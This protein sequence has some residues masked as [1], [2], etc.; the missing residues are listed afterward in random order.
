MSDLIATTGQIKEGQAGYR[1]G[2]TG[3]AF[4][5][6]YQG[7]S[8]AIASG[9]WIDGSIA[10]LGAALNVGSTLIDPF[11]TL[12]AMG[13]EWAMEQVQ[14]LKEALDW[15]AGD[16]ETIETIAMTWDNIAGELF[17]IGEEFGAALEADLPGWNDDAAA[18]YRAMAAANVD[19]TGAF[20]GTA[21]GMGE[22]VR[23]AG[24]LVAMVREFV[25]GFIADCIAKVVV[26]LAEVVFSLGVATPIVAAQMAT[27]V[28][29]WVG[30]IFGWLMGL[31]TSIESLRALLDV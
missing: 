20:A 29:K 1:D 27:A 11:S 9:S 28:V 23:G 15:L 19:L 30:R 13:I 21:A 6:D 16:P 3:F 14:P 22:A 17:A 4:Y 25:R 26:W 18:A 7:I 12:L 31:V 2:G 10:G 5:E 8:Q 24:N